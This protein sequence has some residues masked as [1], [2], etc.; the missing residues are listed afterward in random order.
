MVLAGLLGLVLTLA[1][2]RD[3]PTGRRVAVAARDLAAGV[4]LRA[5]DV[6]FEPVRRQRGRARRTWSASTARGAA[7]SSAPPCS[8][9]A[10]LAA[11][12][13]RGRASADGLRAMSIPV[14]R[15]RAV[16]GRAR[17]RRPRRRGRWPGDDVSTVVAAGAEVLDVDG[18]TTAFGTRRGELTRHARGR[19]ARIAA[20]RRGARRRRLRAH[21]GDRCAARPRTLPPLRDRADRRGE[22][23]V[24]RF[25][26]EI[27]LVLSP[28]RVGRAAPPSLCRSRRCACAV[29]RRG[30]V[31]RARRG[32]HVL[33]ATDR[34]PALT[35]P[36]VDAAPRV[37]PACASWCATTRTSRRRASSPLAWVPTASLA[38]S[39]D[40]AEIVAA[41]W[42][43][44]RRATAPGSGRR[45]SAGRRRRAD[46]RPVERHRR[47]RG[48]SRS[49]V[50]RAP[51]RPRSRSA[52]PRAA[53]GA[54]LGPSWSTPIM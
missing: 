32:V 2:L 17:A 46:G 40:P 5:S 25:E 51:A 49:A 45:A 27:A 21:P 23:P 7:G 12:S 15:A 14:D 11:S 22:R 54:A 31:G 3:E 28:G 37:R 47:R 8:A 52:W 24:A 18:R 29:H 1:A 35:R 43:D 33:V 19:R 42:P 20:A 53:C 41:A 6:R 48:S 26:P 36:F 4:P 9:G 16:N 39:A 44:A 38:A 34:W 13:L 30:A 10:P 50:R